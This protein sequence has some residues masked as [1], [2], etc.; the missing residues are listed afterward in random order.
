MSNYEWR[1]VGTDARQHAFASEGGY[2]DSA[3]MV[4]ILSAEG[5]LGFEEIFG[6]YEVYVS[7]CGLTVPIAMLLTASTGKPCTACRVRTGSLMLT[8]RPRQS[9]STGQHADVARGNGYTASLS[10]SAN[11]FVFLTDVQPSAM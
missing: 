4:S 2:L 7:E 1:L 8:P 6:P 3:D 5:A 9:R 10:P 11:G